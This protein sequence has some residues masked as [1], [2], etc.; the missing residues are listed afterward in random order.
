LSRKTYSA[1][2]A[3]QITWA[4]DPLGRVFGIVG[5]IPHWIYFTRLRKDAALWSIVVISLSGV[6]FLPRCDAAVELRKAAAETVVP[7]KR[8]L[9]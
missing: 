7:A 4:P 3:L 9:N 5:A 2:K 1:P 6:E 8:I